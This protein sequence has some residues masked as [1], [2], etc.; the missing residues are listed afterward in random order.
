[1]RKRWGLIEFNLLLNG[2]A[3]ENLYESS[4][5]RVEILPGEFPYC[6][7]KYGS[8]QRGRDSEIFVSSQQDW[9]DFNEEWPTF[10]ALR[11]H[12]L[13]WNGLKFIILNIVCFLSSNVLVSPFT[14]QFKIDTGM[15]FKCLLFILDFGQMPNFHSFLTSWRVRAF[16]VCQ[17]GANGRH[18]AL[19]SELKQN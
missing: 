16:C 3:Y 12:P 15:G 6:G 5:G 7:L 14:F 17:N 13:L 4:K 11:P 19:K 1:M 18:G 2:C 8:G 9:W 10:P